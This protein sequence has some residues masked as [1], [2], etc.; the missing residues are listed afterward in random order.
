MKFHTIAFDADDTLW[1]NEPHYRQATEQFL[2]LMGQYG[3]REQLRKRLSEIEISNVAW[4]GYGIKSFLLSMIEA[5]VELSAAAVDGK[6]IASVLNIGRGM[7]TTDVE[8]FPGAREILDRLAG[9]YRLMLI[10]KGDLLEQQKKVERSGL[11]DY[12]NHIEIMR[13]KNANSYR[14]LFSLHNIPPKRFLMVGN[15]LRSDI[16]P[17][18]EAGGTAVYIPYESTWIHEV[19]EGEPG[20][21]GVTELSSLADLPAWIESHSK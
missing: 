15:S 14:S 16:L 11:A 2:D 5:A 20:H 7:L 21:Y 8:C 10:T 4:Y 9:D 18:I 1:H 17:V 3:E 12:F 13:E 19:I 6:V